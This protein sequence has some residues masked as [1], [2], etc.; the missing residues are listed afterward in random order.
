MAA[1]RFAMA[2]VIVVGVLVTSGRARAAAG[3]DEQS[4]GDLMFQALKSERRANADD[5]VIGRVLA[6][7][8][9]ESERKKTAMRKR[10]ASRYWRDPWADDPTKPI[11]IPQ[12]PRDVAA[13]ESRAERSARR[14]IAAARVEEAMARADAARERAARAR[15][16]ARAAQSEARAARAEALA[17]QRAFVA[18]NNWNNGNGS[19]GNGGGERRGRAHADRARERDVSAVRDVNNVDVEVTDVKL[20][21]VVPKHAHRRRVAA[22]DGARTG[23]RAGTTVIAAEAPAAEQT[24]PPTSAPAGSQSHDPRGIIIV[25]LATASTLPTAAR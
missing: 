17:A 15:A 21:S 11:L 3:D 2:V 19:S 14:E 10:Y 18:L 5:A 20:S 6:E 4:D 1:S 22:A 25:P 12:P 9:R 13:D 16:E 23:D 24:T 8:K 7:G